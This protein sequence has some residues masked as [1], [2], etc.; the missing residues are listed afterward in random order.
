MDK[1]V[2]NEQV[3]PVQVGMQN[4]E[5]LL[6][7]SF[8]MQA[9]SFLGSEPGTALL[10]RHM[11]IEAKT[12]GKRHVLRLDPSLKQTLCKRCC[13]SL[14]IVKTK[15]GKVLRQCPICFKETWEGDQNPALK[16]KESDDQ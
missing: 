4:G 12:I 1:K 9:A 11:A 14:R 2:A 13:G 6:R 16:I 8:L 15:K 5:N 7:M 3:F 10:Q